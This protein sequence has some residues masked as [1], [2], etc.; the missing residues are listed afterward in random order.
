[1]KMYVTSDVT[2]KTYT[3]ENVHYF[4]NPLQS[5]YYMSWGGSGV[6]IDLFVDGQNKLVFVFEKSTHEKFKEQWH[7]H[8]EAW[9]EEKRLESNNG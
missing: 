9:N 6:L 8:C 5:A 1:M 2:G 4:R 3:P 7:K